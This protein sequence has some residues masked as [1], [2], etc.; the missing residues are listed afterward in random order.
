MNRD[1]VYWRAPSAV[2]A[3]TPSASQVVLTWAPVAGVTSYLVETSTDGLHNW[4]LAATSRTA[5]AT[6][7][8]L[9][10]ATTHF[11]RV[12]AL[13][14]SGD[15]D[16]TAALSVTTLTLAQSWCAAHL[17]NANAP[18]LGDTDK[19]GLVELLEYALGL[20]PR[21]VTLPGPVQSVVQAGGADYLALTFTRNLAATEVTLTVQIFTDLLTW[22]DG[23]SYGPGGIVAANSFTTEAS[24]IASVGGETITVRAKVPVGTGAQFLRLKADL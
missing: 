4:T 1:G 17:G 19:D 6:I 21:V 10:P 13:Y 9:A 3:S 12:R 5:S 20:D 7:G 11:V 2:A 15:S 8:G 24:R 14:P 22:S 18:M 16:T 23:S